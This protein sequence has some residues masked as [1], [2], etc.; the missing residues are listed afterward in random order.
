MWLSQAWKI[1]W[2]VLQTKSECAER[3]TLTFKHLNGVCYKLLWMWHPDGGSVL[4]QRHR[5]K[6]GLRNCSTTEPNP[7]INC[8]KTGA[9]SQ[10]GKKGGRHKSK[11]MNTQ[12]ECNHNM[13][14][15]L[16]LFGYLGK[17]CAAVTTAGTE[18]KVWKEGQRKITTEEH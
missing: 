7:Q 3:K 15:N 2:V 5:A 13:L 16:S 10:K 14:V 8:K 18:T 12:R 9:F 17:A 11:Q 4:L 6:T 1:A